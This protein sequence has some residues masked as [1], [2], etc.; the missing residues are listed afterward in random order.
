MVHGQQ[1]LVIG[2]GL[3]GL[4]AADELARAGAAVTL[5]EAHDRVGGRVRTEREAFGGGQHAELGGEF[6]DGDHEHMLGLV[7]R[8]GLP[9]VPVLATGF[10]H[11]YRPSP[12]DIEVSR[13]APWRVFETWLQPLID[14][15]REA[16]G[17]DSAPGVREIA[18]YSLRDWLRH[19]GAPPAVHAMSALLR[20]FFLADPDELSVLPLI[21]QIVGG[22]SPA[23]TTIHRIAGGNDRLLQALASASRARLLLGHRLQAIDYGAARV[24]AHVL[25]ARGRAVRLD[26][27]AAVLTLPAAALRGVSIAPPLPEAQQRAVA[28]LRY[29]RATKAVVQYQGDALRRRKARAFATDSRLGAFWDASEGQPDTGRD[30]ASMLVFLGGGSAS[31]ALAAAARDGGAALLADLCWLGLA[32]AP[33]LAARAVTWE[34]DPCAGGGYA[35]FGPGFDPAWRPLLSRR[36]GPLTFAGEHT[37]PSHQGYME[38]AVASGVRA[39]RELITGRPA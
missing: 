17:D 34:D 36:A 27:D 23:N 37:S 32:G 10:L 28:A 2:G 12:G 4:A 26:A 24:T 16:Q 35:V 33:V 1:V 31:G 20:G 19:Q 6:I 13:S 5:I 8:F 38:G 7:R 11:R 29:G 25:D 14:R 9:L 22:G 3:A 18:R 30:A 15:Y 39:A 21:E